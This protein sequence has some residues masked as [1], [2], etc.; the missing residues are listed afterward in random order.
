[1]KKRTISALMAATMVLGSMTACGSSGASS[2]AASTNSTDTAA[3]LPN[4]PQVRRKKS[5]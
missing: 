4:L 5:N 3:P 2:E 1:M